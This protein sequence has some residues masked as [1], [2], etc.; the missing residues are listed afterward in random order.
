MYPMEFLYLGALLIMH[1]HYF[2]SSICDTD[3]SICHDLITVW[4]GGRQ[5]AVDPLNKSQERTLSHRR[6]HN[7]GLCKNAIWDLRFFS[8]SL[9]QRY[10]QN[11]RSDKWY[12]S[13]Y[14]RG[15]KQNLMRV[16]FRLAGVMDIT[17]PESL[18]NRH[19]SSARFNLQSDDFSVW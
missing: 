14:E 15:A 7:M 18:D 8:S 17:H 12:Q 11:D 9:M 6:T 16:D 4:F 5:L 10:N 3:I 13:L 2:C 1:L 19:P